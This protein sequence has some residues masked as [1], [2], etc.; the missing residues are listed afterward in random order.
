MFHLPTHSTISPEW[1]DGS[2]GHQVC[3]REKR[4]NISWR[5]KGSHSDALH[6]FAP[7]P[8]FFEETKDLFPSSHPIGILPGKVKS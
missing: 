3:G 5:E 7:Y 2:F 6:L 8:N 1:K 4:A